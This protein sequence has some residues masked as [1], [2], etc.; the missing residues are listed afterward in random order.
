[1]TNKKLS[2][3]SEKTRKPLR[4]KLGADQT[5]TDIHFRTYG[6][7]SHQKLTWVGKEFLL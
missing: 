2:Q 5:A 3:K 1:L 4:V 7:D 6:F